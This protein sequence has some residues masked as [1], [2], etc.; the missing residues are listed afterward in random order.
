MALVPEK[1]QFVSCPVCRGNAAVAYL[2]PDASI[3]RC[4]GCTHVFSDPRSIRKHETYGPEY[5][6]EAHR[7]WFLHPNIRLFRW[8]VGE[9]PPQAGSVIDIGCGRGHF[10]R[11]LRSVRPGLK[12]VGVDLSKNETDPGIEYYQGEITD[13]PLT[14]KF[15]V[16]VSLAVIEHVADVSGFAKRLAALCTPGAQAIV[17]TLDN[18][19]LLYRVARLVNSFGLRTAFNRLYSTH[20]LHHFTER[21]LHLLLESAGISAYKVHRENAPLRAIDIPPGG[22]MLQP[23]MWVGVAT[24]LALGSITGSAYLQTMIGTRR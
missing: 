16:V 15:D 22:R 3:Y 5:Y 14:R 23:V 13:V 7:N 1:D 8:I 18:N 2:H 17:M 10:L 6:E 9:I 4:E 19:S 11:F 21:S 24:I 12:L 20:H